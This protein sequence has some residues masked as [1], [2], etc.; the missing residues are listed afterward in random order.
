MAQVPDVDAAETQEWIEALDAVVRNDGTRRA[1]DLVE[2]VIERARS[3][4]AAIEYVGPTPY[5]NTIPVDAEP[6]LPGDPSLERRVRS[7]IR[8]N[9]I[10]MVL[11]ANR[12]S[13]ELGGHIASYQSAAL[14]YEIGFNHFWHAPSAEHDGDLSTSRATPR[15]ASTLGPSSRAA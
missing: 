7:M 15:R 11:R 12:E 13:S 9:A 10:A 5:V 14:L 6:E 2:R 3:R 4:G 1:H 8:W